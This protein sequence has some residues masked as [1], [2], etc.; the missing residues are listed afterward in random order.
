MRRH[1][2]FFFSFI[3]VFILSNNA[4]SQ[5]TIGGNASSLGGDCYRLTSALNSQA[6]YVYQNAPLNLNEPFDYKFRVYLGTNNGGADGIVFVLRGSLGLPYIGTGGGGL[7]F[8]NLTGTNVGGTV[9][10]EVDTWQNATPQGDPIADHIGIISQGSTNHT[11][12]T[13]LSTAI[14]ASA[15]AAN[16]EDGN[17][18]T[19]NIRWEPSTE[20]FEVYLDCDFR[21]QYQ[22]D[23]MTNIF[24]GDSLVHWGFVGTTG[25]AN[26]D[27]RFCFTETLDSLFVP[28]L[29][30]TICLGE[31]V[32]FNAGPSAVSYLWSPGASLSNISIPN[33]IASPTTSTNYIVTATYQCDTIIDTA[34]VEVISANFTASASIANALCNGDCNGQIDLTVNGPSIYSYTWNNGSTTEDITSLC[35]SS[36]TVTIQDTVDTSA[37]FMCFIQQT[38]TVAQ[39]AVLTSSILNQTKTSCPDGLT[40]DATAQASATGGTT[41]YYYDWT[42]G[43]T[44]VQAVSLCADSAYVTITDANGCESITGLIIEIPDSIV[45]TGFGD[46]LI[47]KT[48]VA[49][50]NVAST[51]GTP[52]FTYIWFEDSLSGTQFSTQPNP[53]VNPLVDKEYFVVS[54]DANNCVGDTSKVLVKVRPELGIELPELDTIC[55]YN[56]ILIS[57][58]GTGGDSLYTFSWSS[59]VFGPNNIFSPDVP[60]WY[61][62]T[63]SDAC[64]SPTYIDSVFVQV[65]G[66]SAIQASISVVDDTLCEGEQTVITATAAGGFK[67][68]AEYRYKWSHS[69]NTGSILTLKPN[70]TKTYIVTVEDLCISEPGI[71]TITVFVGQPEN[72]TIDIRPSKAC[73]ESDVRI[74]LRTF[75]ENSRYDWSFGDAIFVKNHQLDVITENFNTVGCYD[76]NVDILTEYGCESSTTVPCGIQILEKPTAAFDF[77]PDA[78]SNLNPFVLFTDK[79]LNA[80][81]L[82]WFIQGQNFDSDTVLNYDFLATSYPEEV[83]LVAYHANGCSDTITQW[84]NFKLE[85]TVYVP[86]SFTPNGDGK[87]DVFNIVGENISFDNFELAIYDRWGKEVFFTKNPLNGWDGYVVKSGQRAST[88]TYVYLL[89]YKDGDNEPVELTGSIFLGV[90]GERKTTLR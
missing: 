32:Q 3:F 74:S 71:D 77:A 46:T 30:D 75:D 40:C 45:T 55:P 19:L 27:Q 85:P 25:G 66:Y 49:A 13:A 35:Q 81:D 51:G 43:E 87:N 54:T 52:P 86:N 42:N 67:G 28:L 57:V 48:N 83:K 56:N 34:H 76:V 4:L 61:T 84:F 1:L 18:H 9:G 65:G 70:S 62:V 33:P 10:V 50:I 24:A 47:C 80:N 31:T 11:G 12:P 68:P 53:L 16:I 58:A 90:T 59:G 88:G 2:L 64:G 41:P 23:L 44:T 78:P 73:A 15:T 69:T 21:V 5:F 22:G 6:G 79:S 29:D 82:T 60:T 14:Q 39:P 20:I 38:F 26:N 63:V 7:G 17:Y 8:E 89:R 72:P 37:N 36:Y